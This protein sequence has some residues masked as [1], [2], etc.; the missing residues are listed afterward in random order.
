MFKRI[1]ILIPLFLLLLPANSNAQETYELEEQF[2]DADS[3]Y[4]YEDF[5]EA[6][7][8]FMKVLDAEPENYNVNYKI[9]I[10]YLNIPGQKEKSIPYLEKAIEGTTS[11]YRENVFSE[12]EAPIDAYFYLGN[13]YLINNDFSK[14]KKSYE[15]FR[16]EIEKNKGILNLN[17]EEYN[18]EYLAKQI[19]SCEIA[20]KERN[21]PQSF[22]ASNLGNPINTRFSELTPVISGDGKS[23]VFTAQLQFYDAIFYVKKNENGEWG[24]PINLMGQLAVD[25]NTHPT[26]L[27]YDGTKMYLYRDDNFDGNLYVSE[28]KEDGMWSK[29]RKLGEN[30]NTKYWESHAA[31][32][33]DGKKL[34]FTSNREGGYGDL[35]IYV[36]EKTAEGK[37]GPPKN[38]GNVINT[39]WN[40]NTPF[41][42]NNGKTLYFSSEGHHSMGGYDIFVSNLN[43]NRTWTEPYNVGYPVNTTDD[44]LFFTPTWDGKSGYYAQFTDRG[45]GG[46]DIFHLQLSNIPQPP[47]FRVE[48]LHVMDNE[49]DRNTQ[50]FQLVIIDT[51]TND[52]L[53]I[54]DPDD[55]AIEDYTTEDGNYH[56]VYES[57]IL[58]RNGEQIYISQN[59]EIKEKFLDP[60]EL[61]KP[62]DSPELATVPKIK[63]EKDE[64]NM[65]GSPEQEVKIKL[66]L[67]QGN[68]L[69]VTTFVDEKV[70]N[71]EE[72]DIKD[73]SFIYEFTPVE[74]QSQIE[75][76]LVD[77]FNNEKTKRINVNFS[78][79]D[80]DAKLAIQ[81]RTIDISNGQKKVKIKLSLEK[82]SKLYVET[83]MDDELINQESFDINKEDFVYEYEPKEG[84]SK[85]NFRL[86]DKYNN[87]RNE[88]VVISHNP[89]EKD[90]AKLLKDISSYKH[91][92][93]TS[94]IGSI[95]IGNISNTQALIESFY[96]NGKTKGFST[97]ELDAMLISVFLLESKDGATLIRDLHALA[98]GELKTAIDSLIRT[99][100]DF[101]NSEEILLKLREIAPMYGYS[102]EDIS[103][104]IRRYII[105]Y[106]S[107]EELL[108]LLKALSE[109]DP[110]E[111]LQN[112]DASALDIT[113]A[114]E[115]ISLLSR[116][117]IADKET[118]KLLEA[119]LKGKLLIEKIEQ[120]RISSEA[121]PK[122]PADE[123]EQSF[124]NLL[125]YFVLGFVAIGVIILYFNR[126]KKRKIRR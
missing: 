100:E 6:L 111:Y 107:K 4:Y 55:P 57:R 1:L 58:D 24:F 103:E 108:A 12:K 101:Q 71:T 36:S 27:S 25:D 88:E 115:L 62:E 40:E 56:I 16:D 50:Y 45:Y 78:P 86:V 99:K 37:W 42:V 41:L 13:A 109:I 67:E 85:L 9:G 92:N 52:T 94:V 76:R 63:T 7:P 124:M 20:E 64:Y 110:R 51:K 39:Q 53:A 17:K 34:Y 8:L 19:K 80:Q 77:A 46:R 79:L 35:D 23:L 106:Y 15:T 102:T 65:E 89:I 44:N 18:K 113:T 81:D 93:L 104:L 125:I 126:R 73:E 120:A 5:R 2:L 72:F 38:L 83:Y 60:I 48:K 29:V 112:L 84:K 121:K 61:N 32:S 114:D 26:S 47:A 31:I 119:L 105:E 28:L 98:T 43:L 118:T 69:F 70:L 66:S 68:K 90:L 95:D 123:E 14:A 54:L 82:D 10:C 117:D 30:I 74:G 3:W 116:Q 87:V 75:F 33:P 22:V 122:S 59:Y 91:N 11:R 96:E 49:E 97:D 21:N